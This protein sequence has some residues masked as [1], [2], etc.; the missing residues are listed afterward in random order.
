MLEAAGFLQTVYNDTGNPKVSDE[1]TRL[2]RLMADARL[3]E[4]YRDNQGQRDRVIALMLETLPP[5][6]PRNAGVALINNSQNERELAETI[7]NGII[8]GF[9]SR[10]ITVV[11]RRHRTLVEMERNYQLSGNVPDEEMVRIGHEA[12]IN[13]F[14]L[15]SVTGTR[16]SRRL[17]VRMLDV[18]RNTVIYQSPQTNEMNL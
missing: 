18:E 3:F 17:S 10:N 16:A 14:I 11:D 13:T 9:L 12:G 15:V 5:R 2:E 8:E 4:S 1:I 6:L 7:V